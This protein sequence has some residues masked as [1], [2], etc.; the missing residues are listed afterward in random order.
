MKRKNLALLAALGV[1]A[2]LFVAGCEEK[3]SNQDGNQATAA[4]Q[5]SPETQ[6]FYDSLSSQAQKKFMELD[7][8]HRMM[9]MEMAQQSCSGKNDCKGLGGCATNEHS[10]AGKN[11]CKAQGG[12]PVKDANKAV[13]VQYKQQ[14]NQ[15]KEAGED[16]N[17]TSLKANKSYLKR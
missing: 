8:Q 14:Q 5:L 17:A 7:A 10:C 9:A 3:G 12:T 15:K 6:K 11:G 4:E 16:Q 1:G 2:G 13:D